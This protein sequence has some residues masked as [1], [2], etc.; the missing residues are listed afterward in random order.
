M[1]TKALLEI[2]GEAQHSAIVIDRYGD[3]TLHANGYVTADPCY[4][5]SDADYSDFLTTRYQQHP[6][7]DTKCKKLGYV[8]DDPKWR[9]IMWKGYAVFFRGC[10]DGTGFFGHSVDSG[11]V[12]AVPLELCNETTRTALS[13][14]PA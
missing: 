6:T 2:I 12:I 7:I 4:I 14:V 11:W 1:N 3:A 9:H 13:A 5:L 8:R 10:G